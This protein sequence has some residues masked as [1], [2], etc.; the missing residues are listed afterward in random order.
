MPII[1][2]VA[3]RIQLRLAVSSD[4]EAIHDLHAKPETDR[5]NALGIPENLEA[6]Q[7]IMSAQIEENQRENPANYT[8]VIEALDSNTFIGLVGFKLGSLK[9]KTAEIWYKL[10]QEYWN[11]GFATEAVVRILEFG[12][13]NLKLHRISAGCAT[14]NVGSYKVLEK[15]G[16]LR[17]GLS[18]QLIPLKT[19][20]SDCY[21]YAILADDFQLKKSI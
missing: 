6:T 2:L 18:R 12:F 14:A 11:K 4:M 5:F 15:A 16:M 21:E 8:F 19:G 20:W 10:N 9:Y 1:N 7:T 17:E 3:N 13:N